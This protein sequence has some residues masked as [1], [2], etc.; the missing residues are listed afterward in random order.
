MVDNPV[1][2]P[3]EQARDV[4]AS[5]LYPAQRLL[6]VIPA[7]NEE[8]SIGHVIE[9]VRHAVPQA[10]I[11]VIDDGSA[12][13]TAQVARSHQA[14]VIS[15][16]YNL[17]IG[18]NVQ[19]GFI[20]ASQRG[21]D[22]TIQVDGDGQHDPN[23]IPALLAALNTSTCDMVIGSRYI[24]DRGYSTPRLRRL[25][26]IL[27]A[28]LISAIT[29][30]RI[31]D[32][33]SGFRALNRQAIAFSAGDYPFDY[34]EP[35]AIVTFWRAGL[36][37]KEVPVKMNPR[38]GGRSSITPIRSAYY[39]IKVTLAILISLLRERQSKPDGTS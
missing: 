33:T 7:Y 26:S 35:E 3:V 17:G 18:A 22:V 2:T 19:T 27:L 31:T 5:A 21:Y 13:D 1:N 6:I 25:G 12:D 14:T 37:V 38:Y 11:V 10:D 24:E 20:Y 9:R 29:R 30:Q 15:Q 23:E 39:M 8:E 16:P 32:P 4:L 28:A 34:P 36:R